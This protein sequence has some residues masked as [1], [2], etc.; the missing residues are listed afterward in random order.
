MV[1]MM[2]MRV[3]MRMAVATLGMLLPTFME[4]QMKPMMRMMLMLMT[5]LL[6]LRLLTM[7]MVMVLMMMMVMMPMRLLLSLTRSTPKRLPRSPAHGSD[8]HNGGLP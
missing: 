3:M 5:L 2:T 8:H 6:M 7:K 1:L 4:M